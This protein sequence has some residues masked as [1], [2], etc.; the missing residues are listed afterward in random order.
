VPQDICDRFEDNGLGGFRTKDGGSCQFYGVV[1]GVLYGAKY[2]F[3][4]IWD[5]WMLRLSCMGINVDDNEE[6]FRYL[7]RR[8]ED[9]G[10]QSTN[11]IWEFLWVV[12]RLQNKIEE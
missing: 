8:R 4:N 9:W 5:R 11:L 1:L 3:R 6:V 12:E 7:A 10:Y 2:G